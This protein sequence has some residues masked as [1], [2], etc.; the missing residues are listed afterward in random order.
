MANRI[1]RRKLQFAGN[2]SYVLTLPKYWIKSVGL[3]THGSE[4]MIEELPD[5]SVRIF[6]ESMKEAT[7][8]SENELIIRNVGKSK[9]AEEIIRLVLAGYLA[10]KSKITIS[11]KEGEILSP[12][13]IFKI[14][15]LSSKLWGS[16]I[17]ETD[18]EKLVLHDALDPTQ[19][20]IAEIISRAF[21][22]ASNMIT[23]A[24]EA[25]HTMD[26]DIVK[27]VSNTENTLDK[28]YYFCLRQLYQ[29]SNSMMFA[30]IIGILTSEVIDYHLLIKNIE[31]AGD[32]AN[33]IVLSMMDGLDKVDFL[34]EKGE[35]ALNAF[36]ESVNAFLKNNVEMAQ[37]S[38]YMANNLKNMKEMSFQSNNSYSIFKSI[39]RIADYASDISELVIN[40]TTAMKQ[41]T[42]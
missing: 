23:W 29:A 7:D 13:L 17:I 27:M 22:T 20:S 25:L 6:P 9:D 12:K 36:T 14:E 38:I 18:P 30:N 16:E 32:H 1:T 42:E 40:R 5:G 11:A 34:R 33:N 3:D 28:L 10:S 39:L 24:L 4:V 37:N 31:R 41:V 15:E 8:R 35:E 21:S 26:Q 19:M 2:S